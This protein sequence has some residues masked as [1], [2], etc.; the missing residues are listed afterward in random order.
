MEG[1]HTQSFNHNSIGI[2]F[3]GCFLKNLPPISAIK[4]AKKLIEYGVSEGYI[5]KDYRL[6]AHCQCRR[7]VNPGH[8]LYEEIQSWDHWDNSVNV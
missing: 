8:K 2:A 7:S 5:S 6:V 3:I 1:A 4:K